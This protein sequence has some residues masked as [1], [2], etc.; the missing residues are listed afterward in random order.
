MGRLNRADARIELF[1]K[2]QFYDVPRSD[3]F[4]LHCRD[5]SKIGKGK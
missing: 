2:Y 1:P 4:R 5:Q 3:S